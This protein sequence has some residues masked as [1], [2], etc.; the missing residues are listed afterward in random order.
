MTESIKEVR[1]ADKVLRILIDEN[2]E[3]PREWDN[4][5]QMIFTGRKWGSLGDKHNI[6]FDGDYN[7]REEFITKGEAQLRKQIKGI[8]I[9]KAVHLY[10]HSG[11]TISTSYGY[12]YNCRWDS[13]TIGFAIVTKDAIR[14]CYMTKRVTQEMI[15]KA[16]KVLEGEIKILDDY[17]RGDVYSFEVNTVSKCDKGCEHEEYADSCGG[18]YGS[19]FVTNGITEHLDK[20]LAEALINS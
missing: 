5:A 12:P 3:S 17:V 11:A 16:D 13:G 9:C 7:S 19:D 14:K 2:A 10:E 20:E 6:T 18:F 15:D 8:V 1:V 4:L